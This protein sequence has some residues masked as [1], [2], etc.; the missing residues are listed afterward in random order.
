MDLDHAAFELAA[1]AAFGAAASS[2]EWWLGPNRLPATDA[3]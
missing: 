3:A 2:T 1:H